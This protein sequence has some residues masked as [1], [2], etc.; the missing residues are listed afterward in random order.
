MLPIFEGANCFSLTKGP[1]LGGPMCSGH[2]AKIAEISS[3]YDEKVTELKLIYGKFICKLTCR[4]SLYLSN[5]CLMS[6]MLIY[7]ENDVS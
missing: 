7:D 4:R 5:Q 1:L 2:G 3:F 6:P